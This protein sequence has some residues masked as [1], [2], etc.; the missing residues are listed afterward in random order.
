MLGR[1][2]PDL[3]DRALMGCVARL[4]D[5]QNPARSEG[6]S[7]RA[8]ETVGYDGEW[9]MRRIDACR[10]GDCGDEHADDGERSRAAIETIHEFL[11]PQGDERPPQ[12]PS[13]S[14]P[15]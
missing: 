15:G 12:Q 13:P 4:S 7:S 6:E 14:A 5:I 8:V 10:R 3:D 11:H 1:G 2:V 9:T